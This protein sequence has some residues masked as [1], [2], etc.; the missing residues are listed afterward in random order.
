MQNSSDFGQ[1][2]AVGAK[3]AEG[4]KRPSLRSSPAYSNLICISSRIQHTL[5]GTMSAKDSS[6]MN[7]SD[8][9]PAK[10]CPSVPG[11]KTKKSNRES[12]PGQSQTFLVT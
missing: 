7:T 4:C 8:A 11:S 9:C 6:H 3:S 12:H 5:P 10:L 2:L 1:Y